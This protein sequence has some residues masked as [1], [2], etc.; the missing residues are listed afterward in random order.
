M[1]SPNAS[2]TPD[3]SSASRRLGHLALTASIVSVAGTVIAA[4]VI[5]LT[6]GPI[7]SHHGPHLGDTPVW[8]QRLVWVLAASGAVWTVMGVAGIVTGIVAVARD[9]GRG[10][11]TIAIV[12]GVAAPVLAVAVLILA[13]LIGVS[14]I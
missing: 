2:A 7:Q 4:A 11:A 5:G 13:L 9:A 3:V 6:V 12:L 1:T 8:Y 14:L 10:A